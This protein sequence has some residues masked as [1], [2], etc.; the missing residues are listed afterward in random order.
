TYTAQLFSD[1]T[2]SF[3]T[4]AKISFRDYAAV[5]TPSAELPA[6]SIRVGN[7]FINMGVE[8]NTHANVLETETWNGYFAGNWFLGDHTVKF[9]ADYEDNEIYN[10]FGRRINGVYTFQSLDLYEQGISSRYQ[11]FAPVG[12]N[13]DNMAATWN[14]R[15]VGLFVQDSWA[16]SNN[17]TVNYGF[18]VDT[19][20]VGEEPIYNAAASTAFGFDNSATIDGNRTVAPRVGFNYTFNSERATQLRGGFGLFQGAA[21][22][23]WMSNPYSNNGLTY[24]DYF[25]GTGIRSFDPDREDQ[26]SQFTPGTGGTQSID[27]I[28]PDL[29]QPSAWKANLAVDHELPWWGVVAGAEVVLLQ[30]EEA[31][32]YQHLN[33]GAPTR[34]GRDGRALY[35]NN[36]GYNPAN[37]NQSGSSSGG[38]SGRQNRIRSFN[39]A[40]IARPTNKGGSQQATLSFTKPMGSESPWSWTASYT[41]TNADEVSALTSSTSGSQWGNANTFNPNEEVNA[42]SSYEIRDRFAAAISWKHSFFEDLDTT[43]S[44]FGESRSGRP[45]SY[46]FDN[47]ANGDNRTGNDLLYI[48]TGP[49]DVVFGSAAEEA[50]FWAF[51]ESN[52]YLNSHRGQVAERNGDRGRDVNQFDLRV[53]QELPGFFGDNKA[54]VW[55]DIL[56]VG[57]LLNEDWGK[58]QE[59]AFPGSLGVV[60]YG[61]IDAATG[62]Y[63]YRFNS[64]D[65]SR[66]YD[67]RGISRWSVQVGFRYKF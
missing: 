54:E 45:F 34:Y 40:I 48:P 44:V 61:G 52:D 42:T 15:N 7:N 56:N 8:E 37:W 27:F 65:T 51:V 11:L 36:A 1:W 14:L 62:R 38:A 67:D 20:S 17:L 47:D 60:E 49:G 35:W 50:G 2:D 16:F 66:V 58:I 25:F 10:L 21:A 30:V 9:G 5:R 46:V 22:S 57:N 26:L 53:S 63:V 3:S 13:P 28:D 55:M 31:I 29:A 19:P 43:F 32:Y 41:Y 59:V 23:V 64:P 24:T 39:D 6:I 18:R 12:G 33:L 4:E